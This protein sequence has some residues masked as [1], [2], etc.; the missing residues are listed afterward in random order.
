MLNQ[1]SFE[2]NSLGRTDICFK[3]FNL[4][5]TA[6]DVHTNIHHAEFLKVEVPTFYDKKFG[7]LNDWDHI[8]LAMP[9]ATNEERAENFRSI[10][11][12]VD[13]AAVDF[14]TQRCFRKFF[15]LL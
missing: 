6:Q 12:M 1:I 2:V 7:L 14:W 4:P 8:L 9:G 13:N 5:A 3:K 10:F 15:I 11:D